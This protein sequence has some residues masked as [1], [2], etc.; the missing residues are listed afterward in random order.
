M[1]LTLV[2]NIGYSIVAAANLQAFA[3]LNHFIQLL[4]LLKTVPFP[5]EQPYQRV[6]YH[7]QGNADYSQQAS[8]RDANGGHRIILS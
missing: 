3:I 7:E 8:H 4:C 1:Y 5:C 6:L 2:Y